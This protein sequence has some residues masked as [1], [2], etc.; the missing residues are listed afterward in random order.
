MA[1]VENVGEAGAGGRGGGAEMVDD[2]TGGCADVVV[3]AAVFPLCHGRHTKAT[4]PI[5]MTAATPPRTTQARRDPLAGGSS[6]DP[7]ADV[8]ADLLGCGAA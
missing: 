8:A 1:L 5:N 4:K 7:A 6:G 2:A 3:V